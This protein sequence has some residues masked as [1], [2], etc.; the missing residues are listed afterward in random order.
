M[1]VQGEQIPPSNSAGRW[2]VMPANSVGGPDNAV[3]LANNVYPG[4]ALSL[5][6]DAGLGNTCQSAKQLV[7]KPL[8]Q[9]DQSQMWVLSHMKAFDM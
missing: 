1:L 8:V 6:S 5:G 7:L 2:S 9:G 3:V 4:W